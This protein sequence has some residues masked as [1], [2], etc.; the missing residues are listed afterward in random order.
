[1]TQQQLML[2]VLRIGSSLGEDDWKNYVH[3]MK[4]LSAAGLQKATII[5]SAEA[6]VA[7]K[8]EISCLS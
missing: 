6:F 4:V 1:M 8:G 7:T 5:A 3:L 2:E